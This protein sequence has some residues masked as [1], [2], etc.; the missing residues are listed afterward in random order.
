[1]EEMAEKWNQIAHILEREDR[2]LKVAIERQVGTTS[3][4]PNNSKMIL[5]EMPT[6]T[7]IITKCTTKKRKKNKRLDYACLQPALISIK[8]HSLS[9]PFST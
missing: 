4:S 9:C 5:K 1:M 8:T 2:E 7:S 6:G 3:S